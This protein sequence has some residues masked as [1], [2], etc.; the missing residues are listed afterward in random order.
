MTIINSLHEL[1]TPQA[2]QATASYEGSDAEKQGVLTTLYTLLAARMSDEAVI[3][4]TETLEHSDN[5]D[6]LLSASVYDDH[7]QSVNTLYETIASNHNVPVATVSALASAALPQAYRHIKTTAGTTPIP[8]YLASEREGLISGVPAWLV[9]ALPA[10]L[11][12]ATAVPV[13]AKVAPVETT[14][15]LHKE[16][17]PNGSAMKALLPIIGAL[18]FAGLA[19]LLLKS[20]QSTPTPVAAP[21]APVATTEVAPAAALAPATLAIAL[22]ETGSAM[23]ACD[24]DVGSTA[25]RDQIHSAVGGLFTADKCHFD[26]STAVANDMPAL[27]Y[28]PQILQVM[29]GVPDAYVSIADKT[30]MLN[31][32][33]TGTLD[34]LVSQVT[35]IVPSDYIVLAEPVLVEADAIVIANT[36][37]AEAVNT[38][39][40][41]DE[42][43]RALNLQVINFA[44]DSAEIP[45]E[46][47]AI[48]DVAAE[49][50]KMLPDV[51]LKITGHTDNTASHA[52]NKELSERRANAVHD[53]LVSLGVSDDKLDTFGASFDEPIATNATEQGRFRNR[54]IEF[55]LLHGGE[56]VDS[57][58]S[59]DTTTAQ[60]GSVVADTVAG[61]T[62]A[63]ADAATDA[64]AAV[65][66]AATDAAQT[67]QQA[68]TN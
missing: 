31:T 11:L 22:D 32:S 67:V 34:N 18:I 13:A 42:L 43:V 33:D 65:G 39:T 55:T 54:R 30:I 17:K 58:A 5:A 14:G 38:S 7:T 4:R 19:F 57:V 59:A 52:Y 62:G 9:T 41:I 26:V 63:V 44:V 47:K 40:T 10:G 56:M 3:K 68:A 27:Q 35:A 51:H 16:E 48:L 29:N 64:A 46:N 61:A 12:T 1:V 45:A 28:V 15:T 6:Q 50:I 37:A 2:L 36:A 60:A 24:S 23:Y 66:D 8:N 25:L 21:V 49:R 20:C 53:Y